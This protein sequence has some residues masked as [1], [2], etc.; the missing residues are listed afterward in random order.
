MENL[1]RESAYKQAVDDL[2]RDENVASLKVHYAVISKAYTTG[3][4]ML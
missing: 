4:T 1:P 2:A 3:I